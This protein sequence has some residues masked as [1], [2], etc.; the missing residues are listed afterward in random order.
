[1]YFKESTEGLEYIVL[2]DERMNGVREVK[3]K[4]LINLLRNKFFYYMAF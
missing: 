1:M 2:S 4:A 3:L